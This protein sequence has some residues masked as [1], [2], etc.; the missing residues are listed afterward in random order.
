M[1]NFI[2]MNEQKLGNAEKAKGNHQKIIRKA[3]RVGVGVV[4]NANRAYN[5]MP[6]R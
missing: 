2:E 5:N 1:T 6:R 4:S 3:K